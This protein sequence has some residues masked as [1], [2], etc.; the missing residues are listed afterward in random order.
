[1]LV[2]F[3]A[4]M[5]AV[6][7]AFCGVVD[8]TVYNQHPDIELVSPVY[9]C[10]RR[11]YNEYPIERTNAGTVMKI[12]FSLGLD[13]LPGGI[14][15]Y[16]VQRRGNIKSDQQPSADAASTEAIEATSKVMRLLVTWKIERFGEPRVHIVLIE[17]ENELVLNENQLAQLYDKV[18]DQFSRCYDSSKSAWLVNANI[19][20]TVAY[21]VVQK[22][23][24]ELK[25][26]ISEGVKDN[27]TKPA[28]WIDSERQV[29]FLIVVY[30]VLIYI[31][32]LTLQSKMDITIDS[33]C[34][35]VELTSPVHFIKD[36]ACHIHFPQKVDSKSRIEIN[37][38][39][40]LGGDTSGG[41]LL[42]HLQRK[43]SGKSDDR[44]DK[45]KDTSISTQ[46]LVIWEFRID[47]FYS[48]VWLIEHESTLIW[49]ED[50]LKRLYDVYKSQY[51]TDII[52]N[53]GKWMLDDNTRLQ[54]MCEIS[55][56]GFE[57]EVIISEER[58]VLHS[59]KPLWIDS[60][61]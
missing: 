2:I 54:I 45:S 6:S 61:R 47:R 60:N 11:A 46:L 18:N 48:H 53:P 3:L 25:I 21:E 38:K 50:K 4:L 42:Y 33:R 28:L 17:H 43:A 32:S 12:G 23:C 36:I 7:L 58:G 15:M 20:L 14:L 22:E 56:G 1:M 55:H 39:T 59:V 26:T 51:D 35:N 16:E 19:V 44:S 57:M 13:K 30:F 52:F 9:F 37:F 34:S 5:C 24:L 31:V 40:G 10:D 29:S 27:Y 41:A 49:S 8:A